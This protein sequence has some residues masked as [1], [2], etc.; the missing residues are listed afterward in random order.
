VTD[1]LVDDYNTIEVK[2]TN[3]WHNRLVGDDREPDDCTWGEGNTENGNFIGRPI[4]RLPDFLLNGTPRPSAGRV[5]FCVWDYFGVNSPLVPSGLIG[6][7][8]L[9]SMKQ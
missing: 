2:V 1:A 9:R 5:C 8:V 4:R 6:P 7:V 3:T